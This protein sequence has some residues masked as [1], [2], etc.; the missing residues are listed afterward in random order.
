MRREILTER[1]KMQMYNAL[2]ALV[3]EFGTEYVSVF[4]P[5]HWKWFGIK[6]LGPVRLYWH[7]KD[8]IHICVRYGELSINHST[9][10]SIV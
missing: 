7:D 5:E 10:L 6:T 2:I 9:P 3:Q 1:A 8:A 4:C